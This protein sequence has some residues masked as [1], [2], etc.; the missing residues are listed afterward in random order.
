[1]LELNIS[2]LNLNLSYDDVVDMIAKFLM[3]NDHLQT[4]TLL[5][6]DLTSVHTDKIIKSTLSNNC[7]LKL[8]LSDNVIEQ[9]NTEVVTQVLQCVIIQEMR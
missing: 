1:M 7:L 4:L 5:H 8:D 3:N 9:V 2:L 6:C